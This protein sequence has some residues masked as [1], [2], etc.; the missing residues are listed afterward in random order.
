MIEGYESF[1]GIR[2]DQHPTRLGEGLFQTDQNGDRSVLGAWR[3][4]PGRTR[5]AVERQLAPVE[6]IYGWELAGLGHALVVVAG[7]VIEG[8]DSP[9]DHVFAGD[10][11]GASPSGEDGSGS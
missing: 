10:G 8:G 9:A 4:R 6:T 5:L 3:P 2:T 1:K 7:E 11:D